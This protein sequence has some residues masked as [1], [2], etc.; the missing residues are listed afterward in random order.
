MTWLFR[1]VVAG[2][3]LGYTFGGKS[4]AY[5][6]VRPVFVGEAGIVLAFLVF[7]LRRDRFRL[8]RSKAGM[9]ILL[10]MLYGAVRLMPDIER[11]GMLALRDS[12]IWG[13]A[14]FALAGFL[15]FRNGKWTRIPQWY[16]RWAPWILIV[17]PP[18]L[19]F[20]GFM[21]DALP[22]IAAGVPLLYLKPGD[23][24]VHLAGLGAFFIVFRFRWARFP[25]ALMWMLWWLGAA[26]VASYNRGGTLAY[27]IGVGIAWAYRPLR[28]THLRV[29]SITIVSWFVGAAALGSF[30]LVTSHHRNVS[31]EQVSENVL[32]LV[33]Q[34]SDER[35]SSTVSWRLVWWASIVNDALISQRDWF[36]IG[37]GPNLAMIQ[38]Y[39]GNAEEGTRSPHNIVMTFLARTGIIGVSI[40]LILIGMLFVGAYRGI[41]RMSPA[42]MQ[43]KDTLAWL[44]AYWVAML[45]NASVDVYIEGPQGGIPF[46]VLTGCIA[47]GIAD[48]RDG[49]VTPAVHDSTTSDRRNGEVSRGLT[50]GAPPD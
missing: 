17:L 39:D 35:L 50:F 28:K 5:I 47:A 13:Y 37:F 9:M 29:A 38:G 31:L 33:G 19:L 41:G 40:W 46:W 42:S 15:A 21:A 11:Y 30:D 22:E 49:S 18:A 12:V 26:I 3:V 43:A 25:A 8:L 44:L 36:G 1:L 10:L 27:I 24:G 2:L 32:S 16:G 7:V 45:V 14:I 23:V 48:I 4:F 34:S 20:S 6:G